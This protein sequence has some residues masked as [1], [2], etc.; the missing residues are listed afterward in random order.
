MSRPNAALIEEF[1]PGVEVRG[2]VGEHDTL[3]SIDKARRLLGFNRRTAGETPLRPES[4]RAG[5]LDDL[6]GCTPGNPGAIRH[7][8]SVDGHGAA[9]LRQLPGP[10]Y[11]FFF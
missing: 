9:K 7:G 4:S 1:Y 2:D 5:P 10:P 8:R 11:I 6:Q 3:L